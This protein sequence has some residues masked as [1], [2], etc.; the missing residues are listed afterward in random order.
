MLFNLAFLLEFVK[1][2]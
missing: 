1:A 2:P